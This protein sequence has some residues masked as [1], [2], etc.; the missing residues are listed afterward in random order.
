MRPGNSKLTQPN[1]T[2]GHTVDSEDRSTG[3]PGELDFD[4]PQAE[5]LLEQVQASK[6]AM[7]MASRATGR[8]AS[9]LRLTPA[10]LTAN[11]MSVAR[12]TKQVCSLVLLH[13]Y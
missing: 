11:D 13:G 1:T 5:S 2:D 6:D 12:R 8:P 3:T 7:P 4:E 9:Y 10:A